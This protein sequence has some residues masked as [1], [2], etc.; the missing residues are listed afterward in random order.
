MEFCPHKDLYEFF[1]QRRLTER[2]HLD[3]KIQI[4]QGVEYLHSNNIIHR[5]IK[6]TNVLIKNDNPIVAK[7]TDFGFSKFLEEDCDTSLMSTNVGTPAFKAPEFFLRNEQRK[8]EY[9]RNVDIF[10]LGLT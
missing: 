2:Q 1:R 7:V 8:I 5:D 10:A 3:I 4:A 9:H 6:P